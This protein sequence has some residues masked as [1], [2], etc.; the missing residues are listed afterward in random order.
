M[1]RFRGFRSSVCFVCAGLFAIQSPLTTTTCQEASAAETSTP[2]KSAAE[3]SAP[4]TKGAHEKAA[5]QLQGA[6]A[7]LAELQKEAGKPAGAEDGAGVAK[8][9]REL[10][11]KSEGLAAAEAAQAWL[12]AYDLWQAMTPEARMEA[13]QQQQGESLLSELVDALPTP[14][15]WPELAR[16]I[17]ARPVEGSPQVQ[18]AA[19]GLRM[20]GH[21]LA[22]QQDPLKQDLEQ[23]T[24]LVAGAKKGQN[25]SGLVGFISGVF[26]GPDMQDYWKQSVQHSV[27]EV[28]TEL[29]PKSAVE[30]FRTRVE[31]HE[32]D[33]D[34]YLQVPDLVRLVGREEATALLEKALLLEN[35]VLQFNAFGHVEHRESPTI[36]LAR[37][38]ARKHLKEL[39]QPQWQLCFSIDAGDLFEAFALMPKPEQQRVY[40]NGG[41]DAASLWYVMGLIVRGRTQEVVLFLSETP[42][43]GKRARPLFVSYQLTSVLAELARQGHTQKIHAFLVEMLKAHPELPLWEIFVPIAAQR[44]QSKQ[45][46]AMIDAALAEANLPVPA[47]QSLEKVRVKALLASDQID[48]GV[49]QSL[50]LLAEEGDRVG[51]ESDGSRFE[52]ALRI[53][54]IGRLLERDEWVRQGTDLAE[55]LLEDGRNGNNLDSLVNLLIDTQQ[56]ARAERVAIAALAKQVDAEKQQAGMRHRFRGGYMPG[57]ARSALADLSRVYYAAGRPADV[58]TLLTQAPWWGESD[59][60]DMLTEHSPPIAGHGERPKLPLA[61]I[62]ARSLAAENREDEARRIATAMIFRWPAYDP[63]WQLALELTGVEFPR[64]A[65]QVFERDRFEERPL[66]WLAKFYL[67]RGDLAKAADF[68]KQAIA[69]DPS[70]GE[71]GRGDRMRAYGVLAEAIKDKDPKTAAIYDGAVKAIRMAEQADEFYAAGMLSRGIRMYRASLKLFA[72]A[73]CIQ[74]RLAVQLVEAGDLEGAAEHYQR[75]F[76]LMPDSFGRVESHCFGCEGVFRGE[77][78]ETVADRVFTKFVASQPN[79]P[80]VHYLLGYLRESESRGG[81]AVKAFRE[82]VRLDPDYLN[83]WEKLLSAAESEDGALTPAEQENAVFEILRLDPT[84]AHTQPDIAKVRDLARLWNALR[85]NARRV[86]DLERTPLF[87]LKA[88]KNADRQDQEGFVSYHVVGDR[89][90]ALSSQGALM[91]ITS[92]I[93]NAER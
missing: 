11:T 59:I 75:A 77:L 62:A 13:Q 51:E 38:L 1:S 44:G 16:L 21:R 81:E 23:A 34:F 65:E 31:S 3:K 12:A 47:R 91:A 88:A 66:I 20:L 15:A 27:Q 56:L 50:K 19:L 37:E 61:L 76:E 5:Q 55:K 78:A 8:T 64:L 70:D 43:D 93:E 54:Q 83:A 67:G 57:S 25:Q 87:E 36:T 30:Q 58:L 26:R 41:K 79:N 39:K 60:R 73:Y 6:K 72:D 63:G 24:K 40:D 18:I 9:I 53:G 52:A 69:I 17:D 89:R 86:P 32:S 42:A 28:K 85:E 10:A 84:G 33:H 48:E 4:G 14:E 49:A 46:L 74:S 7:A 22:G 80:R 68:A 90:V 92:L 35:V 2:E 82:A 29:D 71:Q 45:A